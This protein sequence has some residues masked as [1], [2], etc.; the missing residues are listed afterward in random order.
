M[1]KWTG[2]RVKQELVERIHKEVEKRGYKSLSEFVS[3]AI[4]Q[5]L[6]TLAKQRV[7]EYL[8]RDKIV[9]T[10]QLQGSDSVWAKMAPEGIV[11]LGVTENFQK[12]LKEIANI[13]TGQVGEEV[14]EGEPF[15]V[16]ESWWFTRDLYSPVS[17]KIVAVN[18]AILRDPFAL[19][20][21]TSQWI[22]KIQSA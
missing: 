6:Q 11:E 3:E 12:Q 15:G 1:T 9:R 18:K 4:Q 5:R 22:L 2:V 14:T 19:N 13:R 21:D 8:E 20:V 7:P 16:A 17:G 10:L